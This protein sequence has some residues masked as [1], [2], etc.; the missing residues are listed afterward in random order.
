MTFWM[1]Q[2]V[3]HRD[4]RWFDDPDSSSAPSAGSTAWP[5][6]IHRYA[7]FPFGG[8]PR[9]CIGN[10]FAQMEASLLLATIARRFRPLMPAGTVI[11]PPHDDPSAPRRDRGRPGSPLT[12]CRSGHG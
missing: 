8:G 9:V 4:P 7:Y 3:I 12:R 5:R 2:W 6:R 11:A 10:S 1:S